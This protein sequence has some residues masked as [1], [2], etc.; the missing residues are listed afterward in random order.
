[1]MNIIMR[2]AKTTRS[3][4]SSQNP[5]PIM[6]MGIPES[7]VPNTGINP[8]INTIRESV[9]IKGNVSPTNNQP[10][11]RRPIIVRMEFTRAMIDWALKIAPKP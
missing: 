5:Y 1:M 8:K 4:I 11:I 3:P 2:I 9:K 10:I 7:I 6:I